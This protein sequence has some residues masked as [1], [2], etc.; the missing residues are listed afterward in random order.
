MQSIHQCIPWI[1]QLGKLLAHSINMS[2][3]TYIV[4]TSR[5]KLNPE[6]I[7]RKT[8]LESKERHFSY[9]K[10]ERMEDRIKYIYK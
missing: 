6:K 8:I 1:V 9:I 10:I 2:T 5:I 7:S 4:H 3:V